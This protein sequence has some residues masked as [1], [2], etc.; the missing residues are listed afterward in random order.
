MKTTFDT[1][2]FLFQL[3]TSAIGT[4]LTGGVYQIERPLD[5][6]LEDIVVG[7][8]PFDEN[9]I[10]VCNVNIFVPDKAVGIAGKPNMVADLKRLGELTDI[11][12]D[13]LDQDTDLGQNYHYR[14]TNQ[15][16]LDVPDTDQHFVNLRLELRLYF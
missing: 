12:V 1:N 5:S 7:T 13:A 16:L 11:V 6:N 3:V 9:Q 8:L 2:A 15:S 14:I 4:T 10:A